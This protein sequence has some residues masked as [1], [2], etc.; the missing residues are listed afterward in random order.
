[1]DRLI[2]VDDKPLNKI[3]INAREDLVQCCSEGNV[4]RHAIT[5]FLPAIT[6]LRKKLKSGRSPSLEP[7]HTPIPKSWETT[8]NISIRV[9][10]Y[11]WAKI[12]SCLEFKRSSHAI[13]VINLALGCFASFQQSS[14]RFPFVKKL[15]G[16]RMKIKCFKI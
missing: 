1:M 12:T 13:N 11:S 6:W 3:E 2:R 14:W 15:R 8:T 9:S 5:R 4:H 16:T 10:S 7:N